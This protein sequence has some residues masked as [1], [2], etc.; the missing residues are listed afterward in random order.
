MFKE[1]RRK[2]RSIDNEQAIKLLEN[3]QYGI[4]STVGE[5]GY[6]YGV[7]LNYIYHRGNIY[8]H[9]AAEGSKL[10]NIAYNNKVSFC[11]V[12]NTEPIP[13]KFSYRYESVIVF[14]R[15]VEV[16]DKEKEDALVALIQKYFGEF[17]EKGVE[18]IQKDGIKAKVIKIN[19]EHLTGKARK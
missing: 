15:A 14:G 12:G 4:L 7:P 6:A 17:M 2:D 18:Y 8:F 9:C 19:I 13:D 3:G 16:Y 1:M 10:D 5:N 11:V